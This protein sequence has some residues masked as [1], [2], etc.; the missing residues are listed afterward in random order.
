MDIMY[1]KKQTRIYN[2]K[3]RGPV[4]RRNET[5][6]IH[7]I[8]VYGEINSDFA[9]EAKLGLGYKRR[10]PMYVAAGAGYRPIRESR[11]GYNERRIAMI[12]F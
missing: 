6:D 3:Q 11:D 8:P 9:V 5:L 2:V 1:N 7:R 12:E 4:I 10:T